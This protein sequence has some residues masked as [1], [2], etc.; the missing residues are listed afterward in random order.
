MGASPWIVSVLREGYSLEFEEEPPLTRTPSVISQYQDPVKQAFMEEEIASLLQKD[1]LEEVLD[2][3]SQGLY[4]RMFLVTKKNWD[5]RP[6]ID[7]SVLNTYLKTQTFKMES[8]D[9][10]RAALLPGW[11]TV[12]IDLKDAYLHVPIHPSARKF[13]RVVVK[14]RVYQFKAL[15]FGL[16][17]APWLFTKIVAEVKAMVHGQGIQ[18]HQFLD[19]WLVK[20]SNYKECNRLARIVIQLVQSLGWLVNFGKSDLIPMQVFN[21]IDTHYNL[22]DYTVFPTEENLAKLKSRLSQLHSGQMLTANQ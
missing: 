15:P 17:P 8:A 6:I 20:A 21:F 16:S 19:N 1:A 3:N 5:W 11:W 22:V 7:L 9:S 2:T 14:G 12:S 18:L 10:I 13:M 4:S